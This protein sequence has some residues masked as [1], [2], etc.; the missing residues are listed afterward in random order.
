MNN[1]IVLI[2]AA[3]SSLKYIGVWGLQHNLLNRV[4]LMYIGVL[5]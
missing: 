2:L 1:K 4:P 3:W 5:Y